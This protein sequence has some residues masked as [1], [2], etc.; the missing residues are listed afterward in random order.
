ML[1]SIGCAT[2]LG[3]V[4]GLIAGLG[5]R[6]CGALEPLRWLLMATPPVIVVVLA[7][8]WFGMGSTMVVFMTIVVLTPRVYVNTVRGMTLQDP[9][10]LAMANVFRFGLWLRLRHLYIP[11][12]AGHT[13]CCV[14]D[15]WIYRN[16]HCGHGRSSRRAIRHLI[17][18][19]QRK[20]CIRQRHPVCLGVGGSAVGCTNRICSVAAFTTAPDGL[21]SGDA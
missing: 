8:M 15:C 6:V 9:Q 16:S 7:M 3:L 19:G 1:L 2:L 20:E 10:L 5:S 18:V 14:A 4:L 12:L 21:E 13:L 11:A 17:C